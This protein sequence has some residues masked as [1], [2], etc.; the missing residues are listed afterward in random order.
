MKRDIESWYGE[1]SF[2]A[3]FVWQS[4]RSESLSD[5][6]LANV[7]ALAGG[8]NGKYD[9]DDGLAIVSECG[10]SLGTEDFWGH[11]EKCTVTVIF[12]QGGGSGCNEEDCPT[13]RNS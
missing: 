12:C 6:V 5:L 7:E 11:V 1:N 3:V 9:Y 4:Q 10:V 8:E 2:P 13:H